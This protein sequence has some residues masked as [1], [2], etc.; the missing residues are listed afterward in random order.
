ML[1]GAC[2]AT[3]CRTELAIDHSVV[4]LDPMQYD[5]YDHA[6]KTSTSRALEVLRTA[7]DPMVMPDGRELLEMASETGLK[8]TTVLFVFRSD[9]GARW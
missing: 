4:C 2:I 5:K 6:S 9:L 1:S 7:F 3:S 8:R